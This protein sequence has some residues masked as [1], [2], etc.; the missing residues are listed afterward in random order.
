MASF[1]IIDHPGYAKRISLP[2]YNGHVCGTTSDAKAAGHAIRS[3]WPAMSEE[4]HLASAKRL[5]GAAGHYNHAASVLRMGACLET[6]GRCEEAT[7]YKVSAIGREEYPPAVKEAIRTAAH[8]AT[9]CLNAAQ[10]HLYAA[11]Y[12][13]R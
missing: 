4:E 11:R 12:L 8:R 1:P 9:D 7:D 6:F 5:E 10:G 3:Y 2:K 13:C